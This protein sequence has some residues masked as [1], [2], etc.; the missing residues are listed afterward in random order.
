MDSIPDPPADKPSSIYPARFQQQQLEI[1]KDQALKELVAPNVASS[2]PQELLGCWKA[3]FENLA[4]LNP[5]P[6][7]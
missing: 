7:N 3:M 2:V 6:G 5:A 4:G 1:F